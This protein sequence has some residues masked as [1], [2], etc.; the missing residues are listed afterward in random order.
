M[1]KRLKFKCWQCDREYSLTRDVQG[2]PKLIVE[3]P[4]CEHEAVADLAPYRS[5]AVEVYRG[6]G[7]GAETI[8]LPDVIPTS[9]L[10]Q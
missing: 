2:Q 5:E 8:T 1:Q 6:D 4:F 3:C 9:Q 7:N 10:P